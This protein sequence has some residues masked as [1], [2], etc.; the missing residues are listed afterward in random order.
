MPMQFLLINVLAATHRDL[1]PLRASHDRL[2]DPAV[3]D[4]DPC[5]E[6][7]GR[8]NQGTSDDERDRARLHGTHSV[9]PVKR[10]SA[11]D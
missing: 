4:P 6:Q 5:R 1:L 10:T 9:F 2:G 7:G 3:S 8:G 11:G